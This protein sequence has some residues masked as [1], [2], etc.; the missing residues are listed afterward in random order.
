MSH[1]LTLDKMQ[2]NSGCD[3]KELGE[4]GVHIR[5][6]GNEQRGTK[7]SGGNLIFG[8]TCSRN[9]PLRKVPMVPAS[10]E[11]CGKIKTELIYS[12]R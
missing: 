8:E 3:A 11:L 1:D 7:G 12:L 10:G 6:G 9:D 4:V 2:L 5:K